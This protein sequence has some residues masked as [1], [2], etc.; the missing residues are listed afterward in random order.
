MREMK[1]YIL[2]GIILLGMTTTLFGQ[3]NLRVAIALNNAAQYY[4]KGKPG[5]AL[6]ILDKIYKRYSDNTRLNYYLSILY[7][8]YLG[9][10]VGAE[11]FY[12]KARQNEPR[13]I[14]PQLLTEDQIK[15]IF[16]P[17]KLNEQ[18]INLRLVL[19]RVRQLFIRN[20]YKEART[21]LQQ[22]GIYLSKADSKEVQRYHLYLA[23][24]YLKLDSLY[25]AAFHFS[26]VQQKLLPPR[27]SQFYS[28]VQ[29]KVQPFLE[30][31]YRRFKKPNEALQI[32]NRTLQNGKYSELQILLDLMEPFIQPGN[33]AYFPLKIYRLKLYVH[34]KN[35]TKGLAYYDQVKKEMEQAG[36]FQ[37][38]MDRMFEVFQQLTLQA[39]QVKIGRQSSLA[40]SLMLKGEYDAGWQIYRELIDANRS[41]KTILGY[42]YYQLAKINYRLGKYKLANQF[43][44]KA[45]EVNF[46]R[47]LLENL[48]TD[49]SN[50]QEFEAEW[51]NK[52]SIARMAA[53][54]RKW[55]TVKNLLLPLLQ[56]PYLRFGLKAPTLMMLARA[57]ESMG[58]IPWA[59]KL[60][61]SARPYTAETDS[62]NTYLAKL[63]KN[64]EKQ[65]F[66]R[67]PEFRI[68]PIYMLTL[69]HRGSVEFKVFPLYKFQYYG[70][71]T[72]LPPLLSYSSGTIPIKGGNLYRVEYDK[73]IFIKRALT[74]GGILALTQFY[75]SFR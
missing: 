42:L 33:P 70:K 48:A 36:V 67:I 7:F 57:Y 40:D 51:Q 41:S 73:K 30:R 20:A 75:L 12:K 6:Q 47:A 69:L 10:K 16:T 53:H 22:A 17:V 15:Q 68:K 72:P 50:A 3:E 13:L 24:T 23:Y 4:Q 31:F 19:K 34:Q 38:Y 1:R 29:K 49:I 60:A 43:V 59:I 62:I 25:Q 58:N 46:N 21:S 8:H 5:K 39:I 65:R 27:E 63:K 44:E 64:S 66:V 32:L 55:N 56:S 28:Q 9:D 61:Q 18:T 35:Y 74:M 26:K 45:G 54:H 71:E 11:E 52:Y 2:W 14:D 37:T